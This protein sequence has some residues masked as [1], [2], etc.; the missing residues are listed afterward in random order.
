MSYDVLIELCLFDA[1]FPICSLS[2][3]K[4]RVGRKRE[5][6]LTWGERVM[7]WPSQGVGKGRI[8]EMFRR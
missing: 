7:T 4:G 8:P 2:V 3:K 6:E 1:V 5:T